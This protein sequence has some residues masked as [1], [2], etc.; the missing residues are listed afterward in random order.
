VAENQWDDTFRRELREE[1]LAQGLT[2]TELADRAGM[3]QQQL[4][5]IENGRQRI[6]LSEAGELA[7]ALRVP[8]ASLVTP[9]P[10]P[11]LAA[12]QAKQRELLELLADTD[13]RLAAMRAEIAEIEELRRRLL[14]TLNLATAHVTTMLKFGPDEALPELD[15]TLEHALQPAGED[16]DGLG[17]KA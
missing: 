12:F 1:R 8:L 3:T 13:A 6:K 7:A 10:G 9:K 2:Q 5:K 4:A 14:D 17:E 11:G 15:K 16:E